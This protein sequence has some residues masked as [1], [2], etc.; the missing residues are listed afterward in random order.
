MDGRKRGKKRKIRGNYCRDPSIGGRAP[1]ILG[2]WGETRV[3]ERHDA[4]HTRYRRYTQSW[5]NGSGDSN[6]SSSSRKQQRR[7]ARCTRA[8]QGT[9]E[10]IHLPR[11]K[12]FCR[13]P[14]PQDYFPAPP[15]RRAKQKYDADLSSLKKLSPPRTGPL[16]RS[17]VAVG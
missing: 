4:P 2:T 14:P 15:G 5:S 9:Y 6:S 8:L 11:Y 12:R 16:S 13:P 10:R 3:T 17:D 1:K 7:R